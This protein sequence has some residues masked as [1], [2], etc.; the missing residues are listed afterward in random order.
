MCSGDSKGERLALAEVCALLSN[1][2]VT[3]A[4]LCRLDFNV[5]ACEPMMIHVL[6]DV[7]V[8]CL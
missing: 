1:I 3:D 7:C 4:F 5:A 6:V 8:F 2:L